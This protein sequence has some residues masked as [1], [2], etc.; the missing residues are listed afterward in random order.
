M[1]DK[2]LAIKGGKLIDGTGRQP[3]ENAF[4][5]IQAG[6][7]KAVGNAREVLAR[8]TWNGASNSRIDFARWQIRR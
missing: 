6:R 1:A 3:I 5:L 7:F 2:I 4:I 8:L